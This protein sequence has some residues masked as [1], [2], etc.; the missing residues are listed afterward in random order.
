MFSYKYCKKTFLNIQ[1][2]NQKLKYLPHV[3]HILVLLK[4]LF[5][6]LF[7]VSHYNTL[8]APF[9]LETIQSQLG[10]FY[11]G[12]LFDLDFNKYKILYENK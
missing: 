7:S 4:S 5:A 12:S 11:S 6:F 8:R 2:E 9:F 10:F 3:F 1:K